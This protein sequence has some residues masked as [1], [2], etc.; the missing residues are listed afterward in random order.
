MTEHFAY[1]DMNFEALKARPAP[2][3]AFKA[4]AS[5][6]AERLPASHAIGCQLLGELH[7]L[8]EA[9]IAYTETIRN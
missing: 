5:E 4:V 7:L 2:P 3:P 1:T 6:R 9:I 8:T